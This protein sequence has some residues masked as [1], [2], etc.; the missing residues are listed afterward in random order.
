MEGVRARRR[1]V[2]PW[3]RSLGV[4][5]LEAR[6]WRSGRALRGPAARTAS[7]GGVLRGAARRLRRRSRLVSIAL[8]L[9]V[10][11][12]LL[13]IG[14]LRR[15]DDSTVK[16]LVAERTPFLTDASEVGSTVGGAPLL[17]ILVGAIA[18]V[19]AFLRKWLIAAFAVFALVVESATYRV[20]SLAVPRERPHVQRLE[21]LPADA[22]YPSGHTAAA[23]AVYAGLVL[24]LT[25]RFPTRALRVS[26]WAVAIVIPSSSPSRGCT[27]GCTIRSTSPEG[28]SSGSA[29]CSCCCSPAARRESR[30][31]R[32]AR[33][34][35]KVR[36]QL[37]SPSRSHEGRGRRPRR[38]DARRRAARAASRARGR[39]RRGARS[40]TRCRRRRRRPSR[41]SG[42]WTRAPSSC[43]PGAATAR[44]GGASTCWPAAEASLAVLP[45][46]TANLFAT[47]LG[48]PRDIE[49]AVAIGLRGD[50]RRL[51]VG[52]FG[53]ERF[54]RH[55]R[56]RLRRGDDPR[57]RR[58]QGADRP[59]RLSLERIAQPARRRLRRR[60]RGRRQRLVRGQGHVHPARQPRRHLRRRRGVP[61]RPPGRRHA[62]ARDRDRR[63]AAPVD[64][65]AR[66]ARRSA[67]RTGPRSSG[68]RRRGR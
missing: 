1:M 22:S 18:L 57:R 35:A 2:A 5:V 53:K 30:T 67:T 10:T 8:G 6:R 23:I 32:G 46:G 19:C 45:A 38:E 56:G 12:V 65:H 13:D 64:A 7:G 3:R 33:G 27:A 24:L 60:D 63:G 48:I 9:L 15:T 44:C 54:A 66:P 51:D 47:N 25:S 43:S 68:P 28:S 26:A 11:D 16:S 14:G 42:R 17:P 61:R 41:S 29:R 55:G 58:P 4:P 52:R 59:R 40:G 20:T 39:G 37:A 62:R 21:D 36:P 49:E 31:R 34:A 50:R